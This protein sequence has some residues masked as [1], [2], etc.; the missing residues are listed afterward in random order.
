M[1]GDENVSGSCRI[2]VKA[3]FLRRGLSFCI[4]HLIIFILILASINKF[5]NLFLYKID[6]SSWI[7]ALI[8]TI[9]VI[10]IEIYFIAF[11]WFWKGT[12]PGKWLLKI[13]VVNDNGGEPDL[14]SILVRNFLRCI[15]FIPP[16]FILPDIICMIFNKSNKRIGDIIAGTYCVKM[17]LP[18]EL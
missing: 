5:F 4:D 9:I 14:N 15:Y 11:E 10:I 18:R 6:F 1:G 12:T 7:F 3:G 16:F 8:V 2:K 13:R 17:T